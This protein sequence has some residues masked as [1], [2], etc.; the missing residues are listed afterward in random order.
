VSTGFQQVTTDITLEEASAIF[1]SIPG[2]VSHSLGQRGFLNN[3]APPVIKDGAGQDVPY[4]GH[5][6]QDLTALDDRWLGY[7]LGLLSG[8]MD[9]V[10]QQLAEAQGAS[11]VA[12]AKLEFIAA[13]LLMIHKKDGD[14]KRPE[15][16]R[17]ALVLMDRRYIEAQSEALYY[18]TYFR[19]VKA[20]ATNAEQNYSAISRRISQRQQDIERQKRTTGINNISGPLFRQP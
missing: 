8:W 20:I 9:Y 15:A 11:T 18:E 4:N 14:K 6:P 16:E 2:R 13:R 12:D 17:K 3:S 7:Y 5:I 1:D 19:H 10:Q